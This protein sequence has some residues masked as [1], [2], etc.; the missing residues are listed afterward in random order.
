M[1]PAE[2]RRRAVIALGGVEG[3][4]RRTA[5]GRGL[6][7]IESLVRDV[8]YGIRTLIKSPGF[9]VAGIVIL[10]LGIGVNTAIFT[11]VNAVVL[12]PL[13]FADADRIVRLWH[14]PPQSTFAGM[15]VFPLSP[16]NFIDWEAQSDVFERMAIYRG[17][18]WTLTG[19]GEPDAVVVY[20]GSRRCCRSSA[21]SRC[22]AAASPG[23]KTTRAARARASGEFVLAHAFGGD[24]SVIGRTITLDR[25]PYTVIG[26]V[27]DLPAFME[28]VHVF[29]PL[30]WTPRER[31]TRANH[32]YARHRQAQ[33]RHRRGPRQR[34][35]DGDL[36]AARGAVSRGHK[37]WGALVRPLQEDMIGEVRDVA[38]GAA[39][40]GGAGAADRVRESRQ[41]D[42]GAHAWPRQ[43]DRGARRARRSRLRV[44][45]QLLAEGVVLG[46]GGGAVGFA[47]A[48]F[49]VGHAQD[50]LRRRAAARQRSDGGYRGAW[51]HRRDRG[52]GGP[53]RGVL[54]GRGSS[55][56]A[57]RT[58]RSRSAPAGGN[59]VGGDGKLRNVLVVSEV[60]LALML[61]VGAGC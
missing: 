8:R 41:P 19:Q 60:A 4:R 56:A 5:I 25:R 18:R 27:P 36:E 14:T 21:C 31:A 49:G 17:G 2:A 54:S 37:D 44:V 22:W 9:A 59:S 42:A 26:I 58:R 53:R 20:R 57:M 48:Y 30:S 43:G 50:R 6:P 39:R 35:H 16:A 51:L 52:G 10:G 33:A 46:I 1:T 32:N 55:V 24:Q 28:N 13:P 11:V 3:T 12:K 15:D 38:D 61:L 40:R 23:P 47:A 34:R 45:Q 7:A 29:V